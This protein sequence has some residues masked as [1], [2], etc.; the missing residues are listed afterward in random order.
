MKIDVSRKRSVFHYDFEIFKD[1]ELCYEALAKRFFKPFFTKTV[2]K[3]V[4]GKEIVSLVQRN[5]LLML[6][7]KTVFPSSGCPYIV[8]KGDQNFG[9]IQERFKLSQPYS[10]AF[11]QD[12]NFT[13]YGHSGNNYSLYRESE[14]IGSIKKEPWTYS[15]GNRY[16]AEFDYDSD[17]LINVMHMLFVDL[18]W[19]TKDSEI[20][21]GISYETN[22]VFGGVKENSDWRPKV[23]PNAPTEMK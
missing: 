4:A 7:E 1:G 2:I 19:H 3:S 11:F 20:S 14:Q 12:K 10:K 6:L 21:W 8:L 22:I 9:R 5:I 15:D 18:A 16:H 17:P 13:I 23:M